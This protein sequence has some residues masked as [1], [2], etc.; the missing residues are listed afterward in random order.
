M[1]YVI[2][3]HGRVPQKSKIFSYVNAVLDHFLQDRLQR[4][5]TLDIKFEKQLF[6]D[7]GNPV[8]GFML[9]RSG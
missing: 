5:I 7:N 6:D 3:L 4:T 8:G 9:G 1:S 2:N